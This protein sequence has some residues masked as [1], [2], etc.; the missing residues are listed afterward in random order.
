MTR[1]EERMEQKWTGLPNDGMLLLDATGLSYEK[2]KWD[3]LQNPEEKYQSSSE[4]N[5]YISK[6]LVNC[7]NIH[8]IN[9]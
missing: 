2:G 3:S 4:Q 5:S 6:S 7:I 9:L 1:K 8:R